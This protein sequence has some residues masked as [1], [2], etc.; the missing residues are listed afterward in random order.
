[1]SVDP[2]QSVGCDCFVL[3]MMTLDVLLLPAA[4]CLQAPR[5]VAGTDW[6]CL[7]TAGVVQCSSEPAGPTS[8]AIA[9]PGAH[10][11]V[12]LGRQ[13]RGVHGHAAALHSPHEAQG[14]YCVR[15]A[16]CCGLHLGFWPGVWFDPG[17]FPLGPVSFH[18]CC[19]MLGV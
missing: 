18:L 2:N 13:G 6:T 3:L 15:V 9:V 17:C 10:D 14:L 12:I 4:V 7:R 19:V 1:M 8:A 16:G 5:A 11:K